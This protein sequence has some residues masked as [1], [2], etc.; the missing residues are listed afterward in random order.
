VVDA[1][2]LRAEPGGAQLLFSA[3][4]LER[5]EV[6]PDQPSAGLQ[7]LQDRPP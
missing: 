2:R 6:E 4:Q 7:S 3:R 5:I 1:E